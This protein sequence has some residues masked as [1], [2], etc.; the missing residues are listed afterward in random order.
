MGMDPCVSSSWP[1]E[2][3]VASLRAS[4]RSMS[5]PQG[6]A[7]E[8]RGVSRRAARGFMVRSVVWVWETAWHRSQHVM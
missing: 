6:D 3:R 2:S 4:V 7:V 1:L 5:V 8:D